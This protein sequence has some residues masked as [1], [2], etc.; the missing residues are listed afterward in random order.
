MNLFD[1]DRNTGFPGDGSTGASQN[2]DMTGAG[3]PGGVGGQYLSTMKVQFAH[4]FA[5]DRIR[6]Y[7]PDGSANLNFTIW[8]GSTFCE[9]YEAT[10]RFPTD[11]VSYNEGS[12]KDLH[13]GGFAGPVL[14]G[15]SAVR[16]NADG[17]YVDLICRLRARRRPHVDTNN[18]AIL[19]TAEAGA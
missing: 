8:A 1:G 3:A 13:L 14:E 18:E 9:P 15:K 19:G 2:C 7:V 17:T 11:S 5:I 12:F 10:L 6:A 4:D 16:K